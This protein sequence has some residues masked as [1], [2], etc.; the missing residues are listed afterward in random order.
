LTMRR[1]HTV[2]RRSSPRHDRPVWYA[3]PYR[4][5]KIIFVVR[6]SP[7][8]NNFAEHRLDLDPAHRTSDVLG[9]THEAARDL[10]CAPSLPRHRAQAVIQHRGV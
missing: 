10:P 9:I 3:S 8:T 1:L 2:D 5:E 6:S 7:H 4:E